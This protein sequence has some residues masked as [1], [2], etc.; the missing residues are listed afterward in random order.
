MKNKKHFR[1]KAAIFSKAVSIVTAS[2]ITAGNF[3]A[4][5]AN[6]VNIP[7]VTTNL[8]SSE[9]EVDN[10]VISNNIIE[11]QQQVAVPEVNDVDVSEPGDPAGGGSTEEPKGEGETPKEGEKDSGLT[12]PP[13]PAGNGDE[14]KSGKE[15][16]PPVAGDTF[17]DDNFTYTINNDLTTVTVKGKVNTL[18]GDISIPATVESDGKSYNVT[19]IGNSAFDGYTNL[20]SVV[21]PGSV[22]KIWDCAFKRCSSLTSAIIPGGVTKIGDSAFVGCTNLKSVTISSGVTSIGIGTF[23]GC[24]SLASIEIP[25]S[26]TSIDGTAFYACS[27]LNSVVIPE[28]VTSIKDRAFYGCTN[29]KYLLIPGGNLATVASS[30]LQ[31]TL[32]SSGTGAVYT[33][34]AFKAGGQWANLG[35]TEESIVHTIDAPAAAQNFKSQNV[36]EGLELS[37]DPV[38][39]ASKYILKRQHT[40]GPETVLSDN[41]KETKYIDKSVDTAG[42]YTYSVVVLKNY[43]DNA[44]EDDPFGKTQL[45]SDPAET[46]VT[47]YSVTAEK[48]EGGSIIID[49]A[50]AVKDEFVKLKVVP[51]KYWAFTEGSL[52]ASSENVYI[53]PDGNSTSFGF[54]MPEEN[55]S[56][57]AE[58]IS[59]YPNLS[60]TDAKTGVILE[61]PEGTFPADAKIDVNEVDKDSSNYSMILENVD[62]SIKNIAERF[63]FY[64][65]KILD[66]SGNKLQPANGNKVKISLPIP[67]G[68]DLND[69]EAIRVE[70][71]DDIEYNE[72]VEEID[73]KNY[74]VFETDHFSD[75]AII[76]KDMSIVNNTPPTH[77]GQS[78][79]DQD[80]GNHDY[81]KGN[82]SDTSDMNPSALVALVALST[83]A[84]YIIVRKKR[85][86]K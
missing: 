25:N 68:Y 23:S 61:A 62:K 75:Y 36:P 16:T 27:G 41:L 22:T 4:V 79:S 7:E 19:A 52:K 69:L 31:G 30:L 18:Q 6:P 1:S 46:K 77:Q 82:F 71:G 24:T 48:I 3:V 20:T 70:A 63:K 14:S 45:K 9:V 72:H 5:S 50:V 28:G 54:K 78:S 12:D 29:L 84:G 11:N 73:G 17:S 42:E 80:S 66:A 34:E 53:N 55:V 43:N 35:I 33:T 86:N 38:A 49:K 47:F 10:G 21:I 8:E 44:A 67:D 15:T 64:S 32:I 65:I 2:A 85:D 74:L 60:Q 59:L 58:F 40:D 81:A 37:W 57:S 83:G 26:V 76:D 39:G 56:L 13:P 51:N